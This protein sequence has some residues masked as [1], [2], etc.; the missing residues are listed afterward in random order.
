MTIM[1]SC[2]HHDDGG[3]VPDNRSRRRM[4]SQLRAATELGQAV[5]Q[6]TKA[7]V[8][9]D[10][11]DVTSLE[12]LSEP[13]ITVGLRP[14]LALWQAMQAWRWIRPMGDDWEPP[15]VPPAGIRVPPDVQTPPE[16]AA[17]PG[18]GPEPR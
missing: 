3:C 1:E 14:F 16:D 9:I 5:E 13:T 6:V 17:P 11:L 4:L 7:G 10:L 8:R 18:E 12:P 2:D 15:M